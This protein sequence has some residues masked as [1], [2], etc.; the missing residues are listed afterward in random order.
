MYFL[1]RLLQNMLQNIINGTESNKEPMFCVKNDI[2]EGNKWSIMKG[3]D[4][5]E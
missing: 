5:E 3:W 4:E 2:Y 1:N